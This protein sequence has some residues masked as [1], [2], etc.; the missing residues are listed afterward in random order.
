MARAK[1]AEGTRGFTALAE[2]V[3]RMVLK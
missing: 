3:T 1:L 2:I